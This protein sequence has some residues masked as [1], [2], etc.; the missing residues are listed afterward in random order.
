VTQYLLVITTVPDADVGQ[1][2]AEK[3]IEER[4]AACVHLQSAGQSIYWWEGKVMQDQEHT[5]LI[6]TKNAAYSR[7]EEKIREI[8]PYD[9]PEIIAIPIQKGSEEYL[10]WIDSETQT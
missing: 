8:H 9:V 2:V 7:L 6:K 5:L 4:L 10:G 1:I 3:I